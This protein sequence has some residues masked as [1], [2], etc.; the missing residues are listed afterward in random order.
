MPALTSLRQQRVLVFEADGP[1]LARPG[2][3]NDFLSACFEHQA[4]WAVIPLERLGPDFLQ[5]STRLAGEAIQKF[6]NYRV[7][8][9]LVATSN[10]TRAAARR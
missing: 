5:L 1:L 7:R 4:D 8:L 9:A 6:V 3:T 10:L 2:D